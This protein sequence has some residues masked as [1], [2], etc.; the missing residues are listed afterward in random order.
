R[1]FNRGLRSVY[2]GL[3]SSAWL[4]GPI[5]LIFAGLLT[6]LVL[7]RREFASRSRSVLLSSDVHDA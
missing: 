5:P 4:A 6:C 2:F 3:A 7:W 1:G